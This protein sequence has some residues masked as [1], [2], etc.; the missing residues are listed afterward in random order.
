MKKISIVLMAASLVLLCACGNN[1]NKKKSETKTAE[2]IDPAMVDIQNGT[3]TLTDKE[4]Q[5]K[6]SY[7]LPASKADEAITLVEKYR[8]FTMLSCD[9]TI[10]NLYGMPVDD[11]KQAIAKL[12]VDINNPAF[13]AIAETKSQDP[14]DSRI[15]KFYEESVKAGTLNLFWEAIAAGTVEQLY[16]LTQNIDKF[17]PCFD[18]QAASEIS[19]RF[20]LVH[21]CVMSLVPYHPEMENRGNQRHQ[22]CRA[23]RPAPRAQGCHQ[24]RTRAAYL[25]YLLTSETDEKDIHH[26]DGRLSGASLLMRKQPEQEEIRD[27]GRR[28]R[29]R[30]GAVHQGRPQDQA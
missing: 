30:G 10:A 3:L 28:H 13:N 19:Y 29:K 14:L 12:L 5:H 25:T 4:K 18:D 8:I 6:P 1:Q 22:R 26:T 27:E 15:M 2:N 20:I 16:I 11:Y 7:L 9:M 24:E 21:E 23:P 17:L